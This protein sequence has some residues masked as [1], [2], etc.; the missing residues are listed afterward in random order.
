ARALLVGAGRRRGVEGACDAA[1]ALAELE[2]RDRVDLPAAY[3]EAHR[4]V[5]RFDDGAHADCVD[6]AR[7]MLAMLA[8]FR[9]PAAVLAAIDADPDADDPSVGLEASD[10][11]DAGVRT[12]DPFAA[13]A[14]A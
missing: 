12:S 8:A 3:V 5:R 7:A 1:M 4:V 14:S 11:D 10:E 2:A 6:R 9:P 13:W